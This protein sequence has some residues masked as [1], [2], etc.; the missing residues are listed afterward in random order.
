MRIS[1]PADQN[2]ADEARFS[3]AKF[4]AHPFF[5]EVNAW[6]V[7]HAGIKP[8][9]DVVDLGC[10]PGATT[11]PLLHK[12]VVPPSVRI[13]AIVPSASALVLAALLMQ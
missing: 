6:L 8:G 4:A 5:R 1:M 12:M 2:G 10:G 11:A 9:S 3:F 13:L 7:G